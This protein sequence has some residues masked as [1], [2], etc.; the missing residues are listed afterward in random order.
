M[1]TFDL[2]LMESGVMCYGD[3]SCYGDKN[4]LKYIVLFSCLDKNLENG[5]CI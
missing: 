5:D 4:D 2:H 1:Y 3:K